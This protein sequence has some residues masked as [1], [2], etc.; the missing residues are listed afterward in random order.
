M[1]KSKHKPTIVIETR[2]GTVVAMYGSKRAANVVLVDWD[3]F[4]D[5]GGPGTPFGLAPLSKMPSDTRSLVER[6]L[7]N[8]KHHE[9][10]S[11]Q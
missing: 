2:G 4:H 8:L 9:G 11:T 10:A 1:S 5:Q 7:A 6:G 3:E